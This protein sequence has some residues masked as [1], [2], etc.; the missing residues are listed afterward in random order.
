MTFGSRPGRAFTPKP[1]PK[2]GD[3]QDLM[4]GFVWAFQQ[5]TPEQQEEFRRQSMRDT[6]AYLSKMQWEKE[7]PTRS[8]DSEFRN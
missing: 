6:Y 5:W 1:L 8:Y 3:L 4:E 2:T 7:Y